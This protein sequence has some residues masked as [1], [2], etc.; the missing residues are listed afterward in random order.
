MVCLILTF[1]I[2]GISASC[3]LQLSTFNDGWCGIESYD[4]DGYPTG[5]ICQDE[6][7]PPAG[8]PQGKNCQIIMT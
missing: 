1:G 3:T 5:Y 7:S 2:N 6:V 4:P 8:Q